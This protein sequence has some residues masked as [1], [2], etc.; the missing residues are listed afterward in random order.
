LISSLKALAKHEHNSSALYSAHVRLLISPTHPEPPP[1]SKVLK[2]ARKY[3]SDM[4]TSHEVWLARLHAEERLA[5]REEAE[6]AWS[7]ARSSVVGSPEDVQRVWSW[8]VVLYAGDG[9]EPQRRI[10]E[11]LLRE[12]MRDSSKSDVH[13]TLL[14][15]YATLHVEI[16][17]SRRGDCVRKIGTAYLPTAKVWATMFAS[18]ASRGEAADDSLLRDVFA[19]WRE[20]ARVEAT[21]AWGR[22][23]LKNGK[24]KE[25]SS[26]VAGAR[27]LLDDAA[28]LDLE[29][30]WTTAL[31][32]VEGDEV[33]L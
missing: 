12:S 8:G 13:E 17:S 30:Q 19:F 2:L 22:W 6:S 28:C 21:V 11:Q 26:L 15:A 29:K 27:A 33:D 25:A 24:G 10:H 18:E 3:T 16:D 14:I 5:S 31:D 32:H 4:P 1:A 23:L 7:A 20:K 9:F